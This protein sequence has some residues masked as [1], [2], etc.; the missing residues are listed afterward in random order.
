[1]E[2]VDRGG[3]LEEEEYLEGFPT[4]WKALRQIA[5]GAVF[6]LGQLTMDIIWWVYEMD[7]QLGQA[8]NEMM[9][10]VVAELGMANVEMMQVA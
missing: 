4:V 8:A 6:R 5:V 2:E 3:S 10:E 1:M 7:F 9:R